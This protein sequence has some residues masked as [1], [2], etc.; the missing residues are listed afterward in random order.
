MIMKVLMISTDRTIFQKES[1]ARQRME[2][3]GELAEELH[4]IIFSKKSIG[5]SPEQITPRVWIYPTQSNTK[6]S[7][8]K[9]ATKLGK[10]IAKDHHIDLVT[11]QDPFECGLA[12]EKIA[13]A[14]NGQLEL[15]VH[16]DLFNPYFAQQNFLNHIR[17]RIARRLLPK[18][19]CIRVVSPL[20][21]ESILERVP[22]VKQKKICINVLPIYVEPFPESISHESIPFFPGI[23]NQ[24]LFVGRFE[25][26]KNLILALRAFGRIASTHP[27]TALVLVGDGSQRKLLERKAK[28]LGINKQVV[29]AGFQK[30]LAPYYRAASIIL[31]TSN[32]EGAGRVLIEAAT[33]G[34]A[35]VS[36][37]VGVAPLLL[38]ETEARFLCPV[39]DEKKIA[40]AL[41]FLL[42]NEQVRHESGMRMES[43]LSRTAFISKDVYMKALQ[44]AWQKCLIL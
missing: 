26:E 15:Q 19:H 21:K 13:R 28:A 40:E 24:I 35:I 33:E 25:E 38:D 27:D 20:I 42:N 2:E 5:A 43:R 18:A 37:N 3:Y 17:V 6:W 44:N 29:F 7:Y 32:F 8:V 39:G 16:T 23:T 1:A 9:N 22:S 30:N 31:L 36:T 4:I 34:K 12:G 11:A 14:V 10:S 41:D